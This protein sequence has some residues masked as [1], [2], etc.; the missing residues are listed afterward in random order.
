MCGSTSEAQRWNR[1]LRHRHVEGPS[2]VFPGSDLQGPVATGIQ[3][4]IDAGPRWC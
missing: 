1:L 2:A 4:T 3:E